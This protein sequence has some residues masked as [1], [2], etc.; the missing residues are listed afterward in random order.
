M[1]RSKIR[2]RL[3]SSLSEGRIVTVVR[4][5][6]DLERTDGLVVALADDW[7]VVHELSD[8]VHLD[9]V[10]ALRLNEVSR[11]WFRD[12]DAYH[13]RALQGLGRKPA[14]FSCADDVDAAGLLAL[15]A[16]KADL[17]S[18]HFEELDDE[19]LALGRLLE[20]RTKKFTLHYLGRDGVWAP[21]TEDW[22][23][24]DVTRIEIGGRYLDALSRFADPYP[25]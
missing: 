21:Q 23:F 14:V 10:V 25:A 3:A 4:D 19:P 9:T 5:G 11:I 1:K 7:V 20:L 12:D 17:V 18:I 15:A 2:R 6:L 16:D 13:H 24:R 8:G 22:R